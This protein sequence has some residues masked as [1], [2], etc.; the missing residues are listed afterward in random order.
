MG[1]E[2]ELE[3]IVTN[4]FQEAISD[5]DLILKSQ[6]RWKTTLLVRT[7]DIVIYK[8]VHPLAVI[9]VRNQIN[10]KDLLAR[11]TDRVRSAISIT[12][13][14]FGIATD[15]VH[16]YFYDKSEKE[17]DFIEVKFEHIVKQLV[18]PAIIKV[19]K[20]DR[21]QVLK[22]ILDA[23]KKHLST[24]DEL[25]EFLN[26]K[27]FLGAIRFDQNKRV[28]YFYDDEVGTNAFENKFFNK[29]L[30]EFKEKEIC[31]YTSLSTIFSMLNNISFRMS[32]IV[33]MNDRSE[34]NY[35]DTYLNGIEKPLIKEHHN[36]ISAINNRYITS[37]TTITKKDDLTL[38]RLY[39]DDGK[40]VC[41]IFD[42]RSSNL[43]KHVLLQKVRYADEK[44]NH[45][46]L[47]FLKQIK[48]D[49]EGST[50]F[51]FEFTKIGYW[52]HFFKPFDYTVENEIRLLIIDTDK[53]EKDKSD[54][55]MTYAHS[56][57]NPI[58]DFR[59]NGKSFPIQLKE[60]ILGPKCPEQETNLVQFQEMI[61]RKKR[62]IAKYFYDSNLDNL[63]VEQSKI[64][65]YR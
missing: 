34:V 11:T 42:V 44:G 30:G 1:L 28:Y 29:L 10:S 49:V 45:R 20:K 54:W 43:N 40:G 17:V 59:L 19:V 13:S 22:I 55:V 53:L 23:A 65:H 35:V 27:S 52:K 37:C 14:R 57:F 16:F 58:I 18:N 6:D 7:F 9:E 64:K 26:S 60:I 61:R 4:R 8:G 63:K 48:D 38:W 50:G 21:E 33:G 41:L 5:S 32:G 51:N 12:N 25:F 36:T 3:Q 2:S 46:E 24:N 39:S 62:E 56:I 47:N 15:N 31:R